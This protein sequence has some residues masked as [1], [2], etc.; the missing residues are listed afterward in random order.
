MSRLKFG[1]FDAEERQKILRLCTRQPIHHQPYARNQDYGQL[2]SLSD[3]GVASTPDIVLANFGNSSTSQPEIT[4]TESLDLEHGPQYNFPTVSGYSFSSNVGSGPEGYLQQQYPYPSS[5]LLLIR[6]DTTSS[7][8]TQQSLSTSSIPTGHMRPQRSPVDRN[9][10][11]TLNTNIG[12]PFQPQSNAYPY[13]LPATGTQQEAAIASGLSGS[14]IRTGIQGRRTLNP[15]APPYTP[16][17]HNQPWYYYSIPQQSFPRPIPA[18]L[19]ST[20]SNL[21]TEFQEHQWNLPAGNLN[22]SEDP[23]SQRWNQM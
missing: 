20:P 5:N 14:E 1:N 22:H 19:T 11:P 17:R 18:M 10:Q 7:H 9:S 12:V 3:T 4:R 13:R 16:V 8:S 15:F 2:R 23:Q 6:S 21:P